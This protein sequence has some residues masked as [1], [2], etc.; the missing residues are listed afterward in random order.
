MSRP[1]GVTRE[2][3]WF[4]IIGSIVALLFVPRAGLQSLFIDG[5][6]SQAAER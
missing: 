5:G 2:L 3:R 1:V 4:A 6:A